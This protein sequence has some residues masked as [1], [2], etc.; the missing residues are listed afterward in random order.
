[1]PRPPR[2]RAAGAYYHVFNRGVE[3][4]PIV[5]DDWDRKMFLRVLGRAIH[6]YGTR[7]FAYC[8]LDNHYH[9]FLQTPEANLDLV[10]RDFQGQYVQYFN[11]IHDRVGPLFQGRYQSPLVQVD[12]YALQVTRYIHRNPVE[13]GL[14][15][16]T[17]LQEYRWSSY[18]SYTG[19][20]P[21]WPWLDT[22]WILSQFHQDAGQALKL[23]VASHQGPGGSAPP[24]TVAHR[25]AAASCAP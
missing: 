20:L 6:Q 19:H 12:A 14:I 18:P 21:R 22:E 9:L 7:L 10:M 5:E 4:R 23:F 11:L 16:A 17:A 3:R 13:A 8:L 24:G 15:T 2:V 25:P 1:M